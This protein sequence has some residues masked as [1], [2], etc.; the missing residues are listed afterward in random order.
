MRLYLGLWSLEPS[1]SSNKTDCAFAVGTAEFSDKRGQ[2]VK[3][4]SLGRQTSGSQF[5]RL[6]FFLLTQRS[7]GIFI[8]EAIIKEI[9]NEWRSYDTWGVINTHYL[10]LVLM[11]SNVFSLVCPIHF[12]S[13][14]KQQVNRRKTI[15]LKVAK[16]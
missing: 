4:R 2:G 14:F 12:K 15:L 7:N 10:K 3:N 5:F 8:S 6:L 11:F 9:E 16:S 13:P 1:S